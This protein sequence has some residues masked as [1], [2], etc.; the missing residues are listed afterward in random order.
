MRHREGPIES[1]EVGIRQLEKLQEEIGEIVRTIG[2]HF[3]PHGVAPA[4]TPEFLFDAA[5][6]VVRFLLVNVKVAVPRDAKGV[7]AV[8]QEAGE[9]ISHVLLNQGSEINV[10]PTVVA[11][12][13]SRQMD[14]ARDGARYLDDGVHRLP[15]FFGPSP[16][17]QVVTLVQELRKGMTRIDRERGKHGENLLLEIAPGP[18]RA[19]RAQFIDV[20][21]VDIVFLKERLNLLVPKG[22][23]LRHHLVHDALDSLKNLRRAHSVRSDIARL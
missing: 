11:L 15:T 23:L 10:V 1:V 9:K 5:Q 21:K 6:E 14:Q 12:L 18:G 19:F 8:E 13:S 17:E 7:H 4:R 16:D 20:T 3:Q 2:F 22:I